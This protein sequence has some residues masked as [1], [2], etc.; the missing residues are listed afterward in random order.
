MINEKVFLNQTELHIEDDNN[1]IIIGENTSITG[2]TNLSAI[3]GTSINIGKDCLFSS[4]IY[5]SAGDSHSIVGLDGKRIN[6]SESIFI[7]NHVWIGTKVICLK[8]SSIASNCI[9]GAGSSVTKKFKEEN[10]I[11]VGN[12][13][14]IVK[15]DIDWLE[16]RI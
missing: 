14:R 16:E 11:L 5:I 10:V 6:P 1:E 8:G 15:S 9:V 4:D 7:G 13:A 3:E 2:T 12:P